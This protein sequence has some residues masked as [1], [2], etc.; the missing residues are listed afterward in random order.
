[1]LEAYADTTEDNINALY[2]M[3]LKRLA[4]LPFGLLIDKWRWDVFSGEVNE[5]NWNK[6][7]WDLRA[8]Y[9]KVTP[10]FD[11]DE[12][13]FDPGSKYHVPANTQYIA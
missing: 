9:Q 8:K 12:T 5:E 4:F 2:S 11:R 1:M 6:H 10:P 13:D 7:W 3:A